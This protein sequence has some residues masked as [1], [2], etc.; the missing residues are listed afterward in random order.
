MMI[1]YNMIKITIFTLSLQISLLF[2]AKL[3]AES[4]VNPPIKNF[5]E[6]LDA[7]K[8]ERISEK[9]DLNTI[10]FNIKPLTWN[11]KNTE[12]GNKYSMVLY[13]DKAKEQFLMFRCY[14]E[15]L[16]L[17]HYYRISKIGSSG[18]EKIYFLDEARFKK[19]SIIN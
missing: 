13:A 17:I 19:Y 6:I 10:P 12:N 18:H 4:Q 14:N 3:F 1:N 2:T 9:T 15:D 16:F 8:S 11:L 7:L 5:E